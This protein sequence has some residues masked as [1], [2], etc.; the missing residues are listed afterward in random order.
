MDRVIKSIDDLLGQ[1]RNLQELWDTLAEVLGR[2][3]DRNMVVSIDKFQLGQS[4]NYGGFTLEAK[5]GVPIKI[6]PFKSRLDTLINIPPPQS[7]AEGIYST[8]DGS[9][10]NSGD[11]SI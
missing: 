9:E 11:K 4:I 8:E 7:K 2:I 5:P 6:L 3:I 10:G 1:V